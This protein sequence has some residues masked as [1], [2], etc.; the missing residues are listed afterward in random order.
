V[1][2]PPATSGSVYEVRRGDTL[3][4]IARHFGTSVTA[5]KRA[6]GLSGSR[7]YP[8]DVLLIPATPSAS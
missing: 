4:D 3:Y 1:S 5:I 7:I 2:S 8:G 6:N